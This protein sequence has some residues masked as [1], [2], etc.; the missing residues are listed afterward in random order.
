VRKWWNR[1]LLLEEEM[2]PS[3][4]G[5]GGGGGLEDNQEVL[6]KATDLTVRK[7]D[8]D[9]TLL[10]NLTW[11][12]RRGERWIVGGGNGAGKS[13]LSR[14]LAL[15]PISAE[16]EAEGSSEKENDNTN[17]QLQILPHLDPDDPR[18]TIGWVSTESHMKIQQQ[19]QQDDDE[20]SESLGTTTRDF[21]LD[22]SRNA[23][24]D[25]A[26]LPVLEWLGILNGKNSC[27]LDRPF[28]SL[29]QGE[30][31]MILLAAAVAARPPLL[32]LDE[33]CQGLDLV[34]RTRLLRVVDTICRSTDMALVYITHHLD[35]ERLL[36]PN[37][38]SHALHLRDR[39]GVY[40]GPIDGYVPEEHYCGD[41]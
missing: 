40:Q 4:V 8:D 5:V 24:W 11:T 39:R 33:P 13:T 7:G 16:V 28:H 30:Q 29:S 31:K 34:H 12:V 38:I 35:E 10:K 3:A 27:L 26:I 17:L 9:I 18:T 14:L 36:L 32:V 20:R 19:Q 25:D 37:S 2:Q 21:L 22:Q 15:H 23:S 1:G 6:V 41:E